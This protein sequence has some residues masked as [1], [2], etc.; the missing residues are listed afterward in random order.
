M[1]QRSP[2]RQSIGVATFSMDEP[3]ILLSG[4][5]DAVFPAPFNVDRPWLGRVRGGGQIDDV[6]YVILM[7]IH[8]APACFGGPRHTSGMAF[9]NAHKSSKE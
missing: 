1:P 6:Q 8:A 5:T 9:T 3:K 4:F 2:Q 7:L